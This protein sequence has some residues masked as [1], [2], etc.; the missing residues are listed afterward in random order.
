MPLP[1]KKI[2][3][4][5]HAFVR[6]LRR[7]HVFR[8]V[9]AYLIASW[10][11]IEVGDVVAPAVGLPDWTV[12]LLVVIAALGLPV[13]AVLA[14]AFDITAAGVRRD[15]GAGAAEPADASPA[16]AS[17]NPSAE[18]PAS[19]AGSAP[20]TPRRLIVLPFRVLRADTE[21]DFLAFALPDAIT[22]SLAGLRSLVVRSSIAGARYDPATDL[23]VL[24]KDAAVDLVLTG[25]LL[26]ADAELEVRTQ[27]T[28]APDGT[29]LWSETSRARVEDLFELQEL[30]TRRIVE[31]LALPLSPREH[32]QLWRDT[33]ATPR[34]Y[35]L[36]LRAN[37]LSIQVDQ[38]A[39][40]RDLYLECLREDPEYAPAWARVARCHRLLGKY[41]TDPEYGEQELERAEEAFR[42][43]LELNPHLPLAH[44]LY[45]SLEVDTGAA[46]QAVVRLLGRLEAGGPDP[47]I[48]AGLVQACRFCGLLDSSLLADRLARRLDPQVRTSVAHTHFMRGD[49]QA[50]LGAYNNADI[51][52]ME[53]VALTALGRGDEAVGRLRA[54]EKSTPGDSLVL[55]YITSLRALL[56][57][58]REESLAALKP[59]P[60]LQR[61]GEGIYY[62]ARH[63]AFLGE[64]EAALQALGRMLK[65]GFFCYPALAHDPWLDS[66]R[67]IPVFEA[68]V[69]RALAR[70]ERA[71][72][73]F[74]V[75]GGDRLLNPMVVSPPARAPA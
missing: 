37:Q 35:E 20:D 33:P 3:S 32:S 43:A 27:L 23:R 34:A 47:E 50:A 10:A 21:T 25:T 48:L 5:L 19:P 11:V 14:W 68:T 42:R 28:A 30:V 60:G 17:A 39:A 22:C 64:R 13:A 54:L 29:L 36:Y 15:D 61:D 24:A 41:A 52:Y 12:G 75:A 4:R 40:A 31:S 46:E 2:G 49:Y 53:A 57:G 71:Q 67:G 63:L 18:E 69:G 1:L 51:G 6:E 66:L 56:E 44:S 72:D 9:A 62:V 74:R 65:F 7:R 45:A 38:W 73:A 58:K 16:H 8:V 26:R 55:L 70:Q 59:A